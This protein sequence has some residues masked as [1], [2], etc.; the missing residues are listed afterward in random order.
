MDFRIKE[1]PKG[2]VVEI[3]K[4]TWYGKRYWTHFIFDPD[5]LYGPWYHESHEA[6]MDS[7]LNRVRWDTVAREM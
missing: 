7:L 5:V 2:F 6:A 1:Y 3:Q 4:K